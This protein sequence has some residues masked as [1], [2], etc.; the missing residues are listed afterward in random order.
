MKK[1]T[2]VECPKCGTQFEI[3]EKTQV[4]TGVVIGKDAGLGTIHP[5]VVNENTKMTMKASDRLE[6][7]KAAG[8]DVSCL[9]A[10]TGADG[11]GCIVEKKGGNIRVVSD[12]D[13]IFT[14]II[15]QGDVPNKKLF[16]R[17]V[18]SQMFHML[19]EEVSCS[20]SITSLIRQK[21]FDYSWKQIEDELFAQYRMYK[22]NDT[23]N[24]MDRNRWFNKNVVVAMMN[25]YLAQLKKRIKGTKIRKC[26]GVPYKRICG[27]NVFVSDIEKKVL[28]PLQSIIKKVKECTDLHMLYVMVR[29]FRYQLK[30]IDWEPSQS[31][32][33]MDAYK[34]SGAFF[35]MQNMIRFH[36]CL[37][38]TDDCTLNKYNSYRY[39]CQKAEEYTYDGWRMIGLL[40]KF[41]KDNNID[42][43]RKMAEW[44][45]K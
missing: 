6:A 22:N 23:E 32:V 13:P 30:H 40:R 34:G 16:R 45:K 12:D 28:E 7:L 43:V 9:F 35:T 3:A 44:R 20:R 25:D 37:I 1:E 11:D 31:A 41:L 2:K 19:H 4:K 29:N 36:G 18:M 5:K 17:W 27:K 14:M 42:L 33:W 39:L 24:F 15:K 21:G 8:V 38:T 26:K 10:M